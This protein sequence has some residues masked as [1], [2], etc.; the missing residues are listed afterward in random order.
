MDIINDIKKIEEKLN[1]LFEE[2][3][4][5]L[6]EQR[7]RKRGLDFNYSE[8]EKDH[9]DAL[10]DIKAIEYRY[11]R[12]IKENAEIIK[13]LDAM[14]DMLPENDR[15]AWQPSKNI[16]CPKEA[17]VSYVVELFENIT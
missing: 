13:Q 3:L 7:E 17:D 5:L 14:V 12:S 9:S 4:S 1:R 6:R 11:D 16:C 8:L 2:R 15:L 10:A